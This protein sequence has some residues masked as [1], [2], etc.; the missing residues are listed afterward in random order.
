MRQN[1]S[2]DVTARF[3]VMLTYLPYKND[4]LTVTN[5]SKMTI[6]LSKL[7]FLLSIDSLKTDWRISCHSD[8]GAI[9]VTI[10]SQGRHLGKG[11]SQNLR[12]KWR[13]IAKHARSTGNAILLRTLRRSR[14]IVFYGPQRRQKRKHTKKNWNELSC[15]SLVAKT[16]QLCSIYVKARRKT[17]FAEPAQGDKNTNFST[18]SQ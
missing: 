9:Y 15:A 16:A 13:K 1:D 3:Y 11:P 14:T 5:L 12:Q 18:R 10:T 4:V 8:R 6:S 17:P 2:F 7:S